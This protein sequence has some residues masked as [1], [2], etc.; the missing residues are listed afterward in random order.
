MI[1]PI[2]LVLLIAAGAFLVIG[3]YTDGDF[4]RPLTSFALLL[5]I[6]S[7]FFPFSDDEQNR[8]KNLNDD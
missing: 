6:L 4:Y 3:Y 1:N 5:A 7:Q 8:T 2:K